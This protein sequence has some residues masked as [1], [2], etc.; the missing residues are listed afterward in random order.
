VQNHG[1]SCGYD[2]AGYLLC[3]RQPREIASPQSSD[4]P[5]DTDGL[6][7]G[8]LRCKVVS[9]IVS[10][11][12]N[13]AVDG[14][15]DHSGPDWEVTGPLTVKLRAENTSDRCARVYTIMVQCSDAAGNLST[16]CVRVTASKHDN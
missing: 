16:S 7:E 6:R 11:T 4:D 9:R 3:D 12:S 5:G 13:E 8:Q 10:V 2:R 14:R 1:D 15:G